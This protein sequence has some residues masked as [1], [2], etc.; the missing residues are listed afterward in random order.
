[1]IKIKEEIDT[2]NKS[3]KRKELLERELKKILE[4][5]IVKYDPEKIFIFGSLAEGKVHEWSDI[6]IVI[7]KDTKKRFM[8]RLKEVALMCDYSVGVD[9][10]VYTPEEIS[11]AINEDN[12]FVR[13][14]VLK[15]GKL[16]YERGKS[17]S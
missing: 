15:K 5:L 12:Y 14:E 16:L 4:T 13:D 2:E 7:I 8:D 1:M 6:D 3:L 9:F 11:E 10:F 17:G